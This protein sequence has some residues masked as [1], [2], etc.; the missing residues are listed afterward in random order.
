MLDLCK[1]LST[2]RF[3]AGDFTDVRHE[4]TLKYLGLRGKEG[5]TKREIVTV[6]TRIHQLN[7]EGNRESIALSKRLISFLKTS[8]VSEIPSSDLNWIWILTENPSDLHSGTNNSL[9]L[10]HNRGA[11]H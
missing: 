5:V 6:A 2:I 8:P 11:I 9:W 3:P 7:A 4:S 10:G 1:N